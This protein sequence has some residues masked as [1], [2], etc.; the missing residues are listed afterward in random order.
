[1]KKGGGELCDGIL[2][3][4]QPR[5]FFGVGVLSQAVTHGSPHK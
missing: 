2:G 1:M 4:R 3:V 5:A